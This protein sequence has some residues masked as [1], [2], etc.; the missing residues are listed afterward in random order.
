MNIKYWTNFSKRKNSTKQP[1]GGTQ[2][3]V[4]L[5]EGTSIEKPV[6]LLTGD[7]FSC[8]YIEAF[9]HYYFVDDIKSIRNGLTEISCSMDVLATFK[10][11]I[12][13][14]N[15]L[16]ERSASFYDDMYSDP[17]V[18]IKNAVVLSEAEVNTTTLFSAS[19]WF[20]VS[21]LNN[22]GSGTGFTVQ[23][24]I[25]S[26]NL[27][28]LAQYINTDWGSGASITTVLDWLQATFLRTADCIIDCIWLPINSSKFTGYCDSLADIT[29]GVDTISGCQGYKLKTPHVAMESFTITLP[30]NYTDF[31]K[32]GPYTQGY[33]YLPGYGIVNFNPLDIEDDIMKLA[34]LFDVSTGDVA[35]F[36]SGNDADNIIA[37]Y[38]YNV[39]V[40]CPVGKVGADVT[41]F[42]TSGLTTAAA[43]AGAMLA[44]AKFQAVSG[45]AAAASGINTLS[46]MTGVT[47]SVHGSK[48]G[49]AII[50]ELDIHVIIESKVT[51]DPASLANET[52]RPC[53]SQH[54]INTCSG[55]VKCVNASVDIPGMSEEKTQVND[56]LNDGFYYE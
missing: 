54:A 37:S 35:V 46:S 49:R 41:G 42:M 3:T 47:A 33:L 2:L 40:Q 32:Y 22:V 6:F 36:M 9:S 4:T 51:Q 5:K 44:P 20:L 8:N 24:F 56:F 27:K 16:I 29:V 39:G 14:Y 50:Q 15:A 7:L 43:I 10:T 48:G 38:T 28:K 1:T 13:S 17:A 18:S 19:G 11:Q 55:Y 26:T 30:H 45:F 12:G 25:D 23:Y 53:M 31:R 52:G 21:V 34:F